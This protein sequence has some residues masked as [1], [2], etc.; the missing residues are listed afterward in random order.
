MLFILIAVKSDPLRLSTSQKREL[1][2]FIKTT[3]NKEEHRRVVAVKQMMEG[4]SYR[5][6]SKNLGVNYRNVCYMIKSEKERDLDCTKS[7]RKNAGRIPKISSDKNKHKIKQIV[8]D[9]PR[10]FW[11]S[12][13]YMEHTAFS[14]IPYQHFRNEGQS[15]ADF[16]NNP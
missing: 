12:K 7:K 1:F 15:N 10:S 11:I 3:R 9:S 5:N 14:S 6:I 8:L 2:D 13:K 16:E 4:M